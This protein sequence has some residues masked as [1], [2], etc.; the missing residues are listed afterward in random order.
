VRCLDG[1]R[2]RKFLSK[3]IGVRRVVLGR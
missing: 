2:S 1:R 3:R